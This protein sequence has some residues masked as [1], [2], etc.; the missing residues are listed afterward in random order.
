V[1]ERKR[2]ETKVFHTPPCS[3]ISIG[4]NNLWAF[5]EAAYDN[6]NCHISTFEPR[7]IANRG[8]GGGP[9]SIPPRIKDRT[10][11]YWGYLGSKMVVNPSLESPPIFSWPVILALTNST[12]HH[13]VLL[14][15]DC[16]GCEHSFFKKLKQKNL[17]QLLPNQIVLESHLKGWNQE[18]V[19]AG[20]PYHAAM[21]MYLILFEAGYVIFTNQIGDGGCEVGF[22]RIERTRED[23]GKGKG[24]GKKERSSKLNLWL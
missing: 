10:T 11:L 6:T 21:E 4:S 2:V 24:E 20:I 14:K 16:E 8:G 17:L 5:E 23:G 12:S 19:R 13:P 9:I 3:I 7:K 15:L 18:D 22:I 1:C